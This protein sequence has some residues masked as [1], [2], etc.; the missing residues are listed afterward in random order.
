MST[1]TILV[2]SLGLILGVS[3][4]GII[5]RR[6]YIFL[7][8]NYKEKSDILAQENTLKL[9]ENLISKEAIVNNKK[10][11]LSKKLKK[12][13][14]L[15]RIVIDRSESFK[16]KEVSLEKEQKELDEA[17]YN[18]KKL[19]RFYK[20]K[21]HQITQM[22][23]NEAREM[24]L[25]N[26]QKDIQDQIKELK[27]EKLDRAES[28]INLESKK[29]LISVMQRLSSQSM[30]DF[31]ATLVQIP[32]EEM[33]GRIIGKEGRNIRTFEHATNTT[34]MIDEAPD[35]VLVSSFDPVKRE[36]ARI[37]LDAL[38]KDGRIHPASIEEEVRKSE[39][40][41]LIKISQLG[42]D[43]VRKLNLLG[44]NIEISNMLGR[45]NHHLSNNQNTLIHSVEV[46]NFCGLIAAELGLDTLIAKRAGLFHDIGKALNEE[47][48]LSHA[49]AGAKFIKHYGEE[50]V[51]SNAVAA[52]H[53]EI[54]PESIYATIVM[55]ADSISASRPGV[56][57]SSMDSFIQRV[58]A[59][60][61]IAKS[62][63]GVE[64]SYAIQSGKELR[65]IVKPDEVSEE[66]S[67]SIAR[68]IRMRIE[69]ELSYT[70]KIDIVV[71]REQ[72]F[73]ETAD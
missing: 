69:N 46:S 6:Q 38:V 25:D 11:E 29:I 59:I 40:E 45:L 43:T 64:E 55:I 54:P 36:I 10:I 39:E 44:V 49:L 16:I 72:R 67:K 57:T 13:E 15:E 51:V 56:R 9:K 17:K 62:I 33:K 30:T 41:L 53:E 26:T 60:E 28:E 4:L 1:D 14:E 65:V 48:G 2:F 12:V 32:N 47:N 24:L 8:E 23:Q 5:M 7:K 21:L 3:L 35:A 34:L 20:L 31:T 66:Q 19:E 73:K 27:K 52:H 18:A 71:I 50:D 22:N 70:G 61:S 63:K 37:A 42:E 58:K 68:K